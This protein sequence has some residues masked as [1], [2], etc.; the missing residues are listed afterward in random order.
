MN[1]FNLEHNMCYI[2]QF[3]CYLYKSKTLKFFQQIEKILTELTSLV[4]GLIYNNQWPYI[5]T[6]CRI[7]NISGKQHMIIIYNMTK[8]FVIFLRYFYTL[9]GKILCNKY[10]M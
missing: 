3:V 8:I 9:S 6:W 10:K 7:E 1:S 2:I 4:Q 5:R